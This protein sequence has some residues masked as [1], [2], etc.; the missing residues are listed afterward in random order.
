MSTVN[1]TRRDDRPGAE[2]QAPTTPLHCPS[3]GQVAFMVTAADGSALAEG[4]RRCWG[5]DLVWQP[6]APA[7]ETARADVGPWHGELAG[8]QTGLVIWRCEHE[9]PKRSEAARCAQ[10][11]Y[12]RRDAERRASRAAALLEV[13]R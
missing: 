11:E 6:P 2:P 10:R 7:V 9:H 12:D 3:C 8:E 4:E 5:C 13:E 1:V